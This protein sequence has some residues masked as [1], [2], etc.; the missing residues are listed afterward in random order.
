MQRFPRLNEADSETWKQEWM[1]DFVARLNEQRL[2]VLID[3]EQAGK[4][5][6]LIAYFKLFRAI[7]IR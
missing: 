6:V 1:V 5:V 4:V 7:Y 3:L 2:K